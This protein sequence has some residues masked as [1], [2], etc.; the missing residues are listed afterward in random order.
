MRCASSQHLLELC[1]DGE[2]SASE[3]VEIQEHIENCPFCGG[4]YRRLEQL[5]K[6]I[7][8]QITR[9]TAPAHLQRS[10]QI[11]LRKAA[12]NEPQPGR[13]RWNWAAV[14]ASVLLFASMAFNISSLRSRHTAAAETLAQE[15]LSSHLRSLMGTHLLDVPSSD[16]HTVKPWFNGK[17]NFSPDVKDFS[18]QGFRLV[19]GRVEYIDDRPAAAL[20]YQ[21]RQHFINLF[22][23]PAPSSYQSGYSEMKRSG[24]NLVSW[25][26]GG[27]T[28][29]AVSDLQTSELEQF[30][31]LYK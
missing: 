16:Q 3:S 12:A 8:R 22:M 13:I 25:T 21:R 27:M 19:G 26:E 15:V 9:H 24:Y 20:V 1:L 30:A 28:C 6:D 10:I 11:A 18:S 7:R 29:W 5:Q 2:L 4:P 14:A 31:Q 17:L 23:W